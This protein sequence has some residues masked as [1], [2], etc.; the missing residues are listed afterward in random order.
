[1]IPPGL[2]HEYWAEM[3]VGQADTTAY[4]SYTHRGQCSTGHGNSYVPGAGH[5][6]AGLPPGVKVEIPAMATLLDVD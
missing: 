3:S 5:H 4:A 2:R 1:V 6:Y